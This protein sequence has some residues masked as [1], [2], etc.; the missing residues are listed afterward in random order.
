MAQEYIPKQPLMAGKIN[1]VVSQ[2]NR[3]HLNHC[4]SNPRSRANFRQDEIR[5]PL[6]RKR[7]IFITL[8]RS[9][10]SARRCILACGLLLAAAAGAQIVPPAQTLDTSQNP[11]IGGTPSGQVTAE[12][13]DLSLNDALDR[14][15]KYN[16]GL[17]TAVQG[18][19][20]V[21]AARLKTL[22]DLLP[23][24][25]AHI[26]EAAEQLNLL[27]LGVPAS[28]LR[29]A[30]PIVGPFYVF[31]ARPTVTENVSLNALRQLRAARESL[32]ASQ[33]DVRNAR[34]LVVLFVGAGYIQALSDQA[35]IDSIQAQF[36]TAQTLFQQ[37]SDMKSAGVIARIDVLRAQVEMQVQ[38]QRLTAAQNDFD[39]AKLA[40]ARSI[41][42]PLG[43]QFRL[44]TAAPYEPNPP[45]ALEEA[46][47]RALA[48]RADYQSALAQQRAAELSVSAAAAERLPSIQIS[49]DYGILGPAP[50]NSHGTFT[51]AATLAIPI[52]PGGRIH[53]D[54]V[55]ATAALKQRQAAAQDAGARV[56]YEVRASFLDLASAAQ[57]VEVARSS[58]QLAGEE[59]QQARDRFAAGV[60]DNIEVVEA[61]ESLALNNVNYIDSLLAHNLAKLELA[62]AL[63][64]AETAVKNYLGGN[65]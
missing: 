46:L 65:P 18:A 34:E 7:R 29:G 51:T 28:F 33:W 32:T 53:A 5:K 3:R 21:R 1:G 4:A 8:Q 42:L 47:N 63:G 59:L 31:D 39:K 64:T 57:Q 41:G 54:V 20:Q 6:I 16:L 12:A 15:V 27:A 50:D 38:Q 10:S 13:I 45:I 19:E 22:S 43:Q 36:T 37:A 56:E 35:R 23:N 62:R 44:T 48:A 9:G 14:G 58:V 26:T 25:N 11:F 60:T 55:A 2:G 40:L 24:I 52:Y 49:A 61:Q 17:L 30:S